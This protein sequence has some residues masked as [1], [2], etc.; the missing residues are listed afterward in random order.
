MT[1]D[2]LA[3]IVPGAEHRGYGLAFGIVASKLCFGELVA[4]WM[5]SPL[6]NAFGDLRHGVSDLIQVLIAVFCRDRSADEV[7]FRWNRWR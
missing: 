2:G 7:F 5:A 6:Q 1:P 4:F 3:R